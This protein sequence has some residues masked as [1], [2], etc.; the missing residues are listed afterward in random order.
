MVAQSIERRLAAII[1]ADVVGF[2]R[3]MGVD[4]TGTLGDL[5]SHRQELIDPEIAQRNGRIVKTMGDGVLVEFGGERERHRDGLVKAG[6][7]E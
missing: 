2:S 7:P 1:A 6:L 3:L 5:K 4:E